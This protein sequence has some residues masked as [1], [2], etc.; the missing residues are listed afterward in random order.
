MIE[1]DAL[2]CSEVENMGFEFSDKS[3]TILVTIGYDLYV[4]TVSPDTVDCLGMEIHEALRR[5]YTKSDALEKE[6]TLAI[7]NK[8]VLAMAAQFLDMEEGLYD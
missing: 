4:G 1:I 8:M 2:R 6:P 5:S 3:H 7:I